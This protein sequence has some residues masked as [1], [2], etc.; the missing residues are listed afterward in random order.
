M[1]HALERRAKK[2]GYAGWVA[3]FVGLVKRACA[4]PSY[5]SLSVGQREKLLERIRYHASEFA[6]ILVDMGDAEVALDG[7][8]KVPLASVVSGI[9]YLAVGKIYEA[10]RDPLTG[11]YI[12]AK[13]STAT[14]FARRFAAELRN[15][16]GSP[17][18]GIV[19]TVTNGLYGTHYGA[20]DVYNLR[21]RTKKF[22]IRP[23]RNRSFANRRQVR[24]AG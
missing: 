13:Q 4:I 7:K 18:D 15:H 24:K 14:R 23:R 6:Q 3:L 17:L 21:T 2:N 20:A 9:A 10:D 16:Y 5:Y 1:W 12:E 19:A 11:A 22:A 8:T